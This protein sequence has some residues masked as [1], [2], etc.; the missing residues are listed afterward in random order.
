MK[1]RNISKTDINTLHIKLV[2]SKANGRDPNQNKKTVDFD[3]N[4]E[5]DTP[6]SVADD[7]ADSFTLSMTDRQICEA[8]LREWLAMTLS[9]ET[10]DPCFTDNN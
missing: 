3:Y 9:P 4:L 6:D 1:Y 8:G 2:M 5:T 7:I 10:E